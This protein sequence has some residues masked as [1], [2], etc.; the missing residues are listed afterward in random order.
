MLAGAGSGKTTVLI[1]RIANIIRF[2]GGFQCETA[3][4]YAGEDE[5]RELVEY[6]RRPA[7]GK[8]RARDGP[9]RREPLPS[10]ADPRDHLHK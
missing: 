7:G 4:E 3:P 2:G 10:V 5:L 1:N 8:A 6:P 9:V